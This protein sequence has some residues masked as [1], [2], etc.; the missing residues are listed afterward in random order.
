MAKVCVPETRVLW[1]HS[2]AWMAF[3]TLVAG[4]RQSRIRKS[5]A[6]RPHSPLQGVEGHLPLVLEVAG[7]SVR[8]LR[9][10]MMFEYTEAR[11]IVKNKNTEN[12]CILTCA[13]KGTGRRNQDQS[14]QQVDKFRRKSNRMSNGSSSRL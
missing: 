6:V 13:M 12:E 3:E 11:R 1:L 9:D 7:S 14:I 5:D 4:E 8:L 2:A 10:G